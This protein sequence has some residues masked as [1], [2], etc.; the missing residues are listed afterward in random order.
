MADEGEINDIANEMQLQQARGEI[1]RQQIQ[2]MQ[3]NM[4]EI[5]GAVDAINNLKKAKGDTLVPI[6]AGILISCP[7]PSSDH[8]LVDIGA[9]IIVEKKP[10]EAV[11]I[12]QERQKKIMG[13]VEETQKG[14]SE[15]VKVIE[16]LTQRASLIA[17][18]GE[19]GNVRPS[20]E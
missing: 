4:L 12:L 2:Q 20:E 6:G 9:N 8:V 18:E 19:R 11:K 10:D 17:A 1:F 5:S 14:L 13:A 7:K 3:K 16:S 15:V